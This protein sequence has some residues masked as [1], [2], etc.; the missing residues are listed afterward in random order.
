[1]DGLLRRGGGVG[2]Y[3]GP[4]VTQIIEKV[5]DRLFESIIYYE[6]HLRH[7]LLHK[8]TQKKYN[9]DCKRH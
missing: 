7:R 6:Q 8:H 2:F 4:T 1:M 9:A 3:D 5:G